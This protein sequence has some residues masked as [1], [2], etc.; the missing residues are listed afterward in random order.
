MIFF[1]ILKHKTRA[2]HPTHQFVPP[3]N[4]C[5]PVPV[6]KANKKYVCITLHVC[7]L[8]LQCQTS[9]SPFTKTEKS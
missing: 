3:A 8:I 9:C 2:S 7:H 6:I 5:G 1:N 4:P